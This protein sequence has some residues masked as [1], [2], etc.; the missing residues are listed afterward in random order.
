MTDAIEAASK[1]WYEAHTGLSWADTTEDVRN[2]FRA[3]VQP[4][5]EALEVRP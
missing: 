4:I 2:T 3:G 1:A 5:V